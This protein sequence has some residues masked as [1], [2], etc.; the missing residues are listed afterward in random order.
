[1]RE[2]AQQRGQSRAAVIPIARHDPQ[3]AAVVAARHL[4][5]QQG[6]AVEAQASLAT[7]LAISA[8]VETVVELPAQ[9]ALGARHTHALQRDGGIQQLQIGFATAPRRNDQ[10]AL[11]HGTQGLPGEYA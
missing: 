4:D 5:P 10:G 3:I 9:A 6:A 1:M 2:P 11:V 7:L 8:D